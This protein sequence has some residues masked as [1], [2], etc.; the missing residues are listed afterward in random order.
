MRCTPLLPLLLVLLLPSPTT[1]NALSTALANLSPTDTPLSLLAHTATMLS[2]H[3]NALFV[4][5]TKSRAVSE[6][7]RSI[8]ELQHC[9]QSPDAAQSQRWWG[10]KLW[11]WASERKRDPSGCVIG[12]LRAVAA[13]Y[14]VRA[15]IA[16]WITAEKDTVK[17][18][19][20]KRV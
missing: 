1:S 9:L 16:E 2:G 19:T 15:N 17:Q 11:P 10:I 3:G 8:E 6:L 12:P 5:L 13:V 18:R 4:T 20:R 14:L 7:F